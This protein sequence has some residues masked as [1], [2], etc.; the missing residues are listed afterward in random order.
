[1][2][3]FAALLLVLA[4]MPATV[5]AQSYSAT[6]SGAQEVPGPGDANGVGIAVIT[7]DGTSIRYSVLHQGITAPTGAHIHTGATGVAGPVI[8]P[9]DHNAL[10]S[11]VV[12]GV[13]ADVINQI[14]A[15][16]SGFYVNVHSGEFPNGAIRGQL[17]E[18]T[19]GAGTQT[20]YI[21]V[22][23]KVRGDA[24]TNFVTDLR[25]VNTG[26][27][28]A[29][30]TLDFF[31]QNAA[32][33][34]APTVSRSIMV[35]PGEQK[36]LDDVVGETLGVDAVLG[37]LRITADTNVVASARIIND[38]RG[39]SAGTTGFATDAQP[40]G[41]TSGTM[42]FL[43]QNA[44]YR[45]N[46]GYFNPSSS[47]ATLTMVARSTMTGGVLGSTTV[48]VPPYAML[49]QPVFAAIGSLPEGSRTQDD[50]YVTWTSDAPMF[51]YGAVTDNVTGDAVLNQ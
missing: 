39:E 7:I 47:P 51:V 2:K 22:V 24:G 9:L 50:F 25:I 32:G 19:A 18:V 41:E 38:L 4:V 44:D 45:T 12:T 33:N 21:P 36:V 10:M 31:T 29:N 3:R 27:S 6:L 13:A 8:V 49:Q 20:S 40:S 43:T 23:G 34:A 28:V 37:G 46:I 15:N 48:V 1:M 42:M 16:P 5:F 14:K 17:T 11:G 26:S 30:V 35:A